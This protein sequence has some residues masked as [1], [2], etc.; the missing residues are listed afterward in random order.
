[1]LSQIKDN[2]EYYEIIIIKVYW[3]K[4]E[5]LDNGFI[6][7]FDVEGNYNFFIVFLLIYLVII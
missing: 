4:G 3:K 5:K 7:N 1:M 2:G 6:F